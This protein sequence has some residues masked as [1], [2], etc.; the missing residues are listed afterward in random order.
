MSLVEKIGTCK[1][2]HQS[3]VIK[4]P[5]SFTDEMV[6]EEVTKKCVCEAAVEES[7]IN[8]IIA[9]T[10]MQIKDIFKGKDELEV[11]R[12]LALSV[13]ENMARYRIHKLNIGFAEYTLNMKRKDKAIALT[14]KYQEEI[15]SE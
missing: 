15:K 4:V 5:E 6:N 12:D 2:C 8:Q 14:L 13:V 9:H 7:S 11:M 3:M 10:E 1:F